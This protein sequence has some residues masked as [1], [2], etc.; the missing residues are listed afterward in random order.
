MHRPI[1]FDFD[2][3]IVDSE[4]ICNQALADHLTAH[5]CPTTYD[6]A[7]AAYIGLRMSDCLQ[8]AKQIHRRDLPADFA[9]TLHHRCTLML[10]EGLQ[11]VPGATAFARNC[12]SGRTAIASSTREHDIRACLALVGLTGIFEG[13]IYS[14]AAIERGKP[15]PDIFLLAA[16]GIGAAPRDCIVI[17]D[18]T[19]GTQGAVAAGMTVI[20]LTA[21]SHCGPGHADRLTAA[22]AHTIARSYDEVAAYIEMLR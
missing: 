10:R 13:R 16:S 22:G 2:G 4:V 20:G 17:E 3:V 9:D 11:P 8:K 12:V 21:G 15:H 6:E 18:G 19:L 14:A 5:G 1:I 7:V